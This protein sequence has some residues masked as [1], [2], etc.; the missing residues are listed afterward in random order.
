MKTELYYGNKKECIY[1]GYAGIIFGV[2]RDRIIEEG[3]YFIKVGEKEYIELDELLS[4]KKKKIV[5]KTF[6]RKRGE[7]FVGDLVLVDDLVK[8]IMNTKKK[9]LCK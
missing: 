2:E 9:T 5:L 3:L 8:S 1:A 7:I 6:A 4:T